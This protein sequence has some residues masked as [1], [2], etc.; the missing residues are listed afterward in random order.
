MGN[1]EGTAL[2]D[3]YRAFTT[4]LVAAVG[5]HT[6]GAEWDGYAGDAQHTALSTVASQPLQSTHWQTPVDLAPQYWGSEL[7]SLLKLTIT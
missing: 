7:S 4:T 3:E 5:V 2:G 6:R 1:Q